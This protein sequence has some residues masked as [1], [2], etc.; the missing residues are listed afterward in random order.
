[1]QTAMFLRKV[2]PVGVILLFMSVGFLPP[3]NSDVVE[4]DDYIVTPIA[5]FNVL[6][7]NEPPYIIDIYID[8]ENC[9]ITIS[10]IVYEPS[11]TV[12]VQIDSGPPFCCNDTCTWV[13]HIEG[14]L[15]I[16]YW[17]T[18]EPP[19]TSGE[20]ILDC[21]PPTC[22][23]T[24]PEEGALYLFGEKIM[25]RKFSNITICIGKVPIAVSASDGVGSG[26]KMV[27]FDFSNGDSGYDTRAP[28]E[29]MFRQKYF[30]D[31]VVTAY[32]IDLFDLISEDSITIT[33]YSL[34]LI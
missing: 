30:G 29:Y 17:S 15:S 9:T 1:M 24:S 3:I 5:D 7:A 4:K 31:L 2:S 18:I 28:Y 6:P 11:I 14:L 13:F 34:G 25:N 16:T 22:T 27:L 33:V 23:L 26:V 12:C 8:Y 21:T 19:K 20:I 10:V 32:A